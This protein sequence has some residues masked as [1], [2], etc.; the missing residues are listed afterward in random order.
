MENM[1]LMDG[2]SFKLTFEEKISGR[3]TERINTN[4]NTILKPTYLYCLNTKRN[5]FI[6]CSLLRGNGIIS[7]Q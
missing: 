7:K 2:F 5:L 3:V 4:K 1:L 6:S